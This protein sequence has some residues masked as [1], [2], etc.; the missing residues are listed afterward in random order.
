MGV[1]CE[2][3]LFLTGR[4]TLRRF[5]LLQLDQGPHHGRQRAARLSTLALVPGSGLGPTV[6]T[7]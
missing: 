5:S 2:E 7:L 6:V 3:K 4:S 1:T